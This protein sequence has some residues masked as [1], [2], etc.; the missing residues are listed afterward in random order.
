MHSIHTH[1]E[2]ML[3]VYIFLTDVCTHTYMHVSFLSTHL[4]RGEFFLVNCIVCVLR[5]VVHLKIR[6]FHLEDIDVFI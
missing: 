4:C 6:V 5:W 2:I 1:V 3:C